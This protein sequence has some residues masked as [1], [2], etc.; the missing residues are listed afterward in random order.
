[1]SFQEGSVPYSQ[2][3]AVTGLGSNDSVCN[4][5]QNRLQFAQSLQIYNVTAI[6][7]F[8]NI[9]NQT[10]L[11]TPAYR[12]SIAVFESFSLQGVKA[13][14]AASTAYAHRNENITV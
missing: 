1:M 5:G 8:Y 2:L 4:H 12:D 13:V 14:D 7:L 6:R 11:E 9:F 3:A 10:T